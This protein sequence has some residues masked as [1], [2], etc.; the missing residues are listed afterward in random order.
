VSAGGPNLRFRN[1]TKH[2]ILIR[3]ASD[4]ITTKFVIYGTDEGRKVEYETSEF[5]DVV[6]QTVES[7][8]NKSLGTGTSL[9]L[10]DGQPG[11]KIKVIRVVKDAKGAIIHKNTFVSS[12]PMLPKEIEVGTAKPTTTT[13]KP[14]TT[15]TTEPPTPTTEPATTTT[16]TTAS[17]AA[18]APSG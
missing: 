6:E 10:V 12:W 9:V 18:T 3:G 15:T 14:T 1:D 5:Y 17:T 4:G 2:H 13:V 11:R 7:S 16:D 8:T